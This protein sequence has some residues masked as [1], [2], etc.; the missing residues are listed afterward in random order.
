MYV[1]D[2]EG[3]VMR[4]APAEAHARPLLDDTQL[5]PVEQK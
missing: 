1:A 3:T 5:P 4:R 2:Q